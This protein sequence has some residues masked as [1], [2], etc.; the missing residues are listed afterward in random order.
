MPLWSASTYSVKKCYRSSRRR[1]SVKKVFLKVSQVSQKTPVLESLFNKVTGFQVNYIKKRIQHRCFPVN[2]AKFL[3]TPILKKICIK[4]LLVLVFCKN[5]NARPTV[6]FIILTRTKRLRSNLMHFL[7]ES[8]RRGEIE[9]TVH[10]CSIKK[11]ILKKLW[12]TN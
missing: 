5:R 6:F 7:K 11:T 4:L 8:L 12:K 10:R 9:A 1:C 3:R 2:N